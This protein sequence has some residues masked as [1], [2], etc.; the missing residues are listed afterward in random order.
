MAAE[1]NES[2]QTEGIETAGSTACPVSDATIDVCVCP[3]C[4][5]AIGAGEHV[6]SRCG[7]CLK[8]G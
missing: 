6:C 3:R 5:A 1:R 2:Q 4:Q 7:E 8:C